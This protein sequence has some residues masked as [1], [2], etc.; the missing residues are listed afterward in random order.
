MKTNKRK[1]PAIGKFARTGKNKKQRGESNEMTRD[2]NGKSAYFLAWMD[3]KPG[4]LLSSI[5][6]YAAEVSRNTVNANGQWEKK[7]FPQPTVIQIYNSG[8]GGTDSCD[9]TLSYTRPKVKT[10]SWQPKI[11]IHF[12]NAAVFNSYVL[13]KSFFKK[14]SSYHIIDFIRPL[15]EQLAQDQ[16]EK[17]YHTPSQIYHNRNKDW[18]SWEK[19]TSRFIG[20]HFPFIVVNRMV[21]SDGR[22]RNLTRGSCMVCARKIT[23]RCK[24]CK[25]F[26]C[27]E[28]FDGKTSCFETF[29]TVK[30]FVEKK[31]HRF[32]LPTD[33]ENAEDSG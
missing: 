14:D 7:Q 24:Q 13:Y 9:Q 1:L 32:E 30:N 22:A 8:M 2:F 31:T 25:V 26:L 28:E 18:K 20:T 5:K 3:K 33:S 16:R 23:I 19:D 11:F 17:Y 29:H 12:V 6:S 15:I 21:E 10:L 4:H 27:C